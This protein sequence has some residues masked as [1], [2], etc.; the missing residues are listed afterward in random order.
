MSQRVESIINKE[1][2]RKT[3]VKVD[4]PEG[5]TVVQVVIERT[6]IEA[7]QKNVDICRATLRT[8]EEKGIGSVKWAGGRADYSDVRPGRV[9]LWTTGRWQIA[10]AKKVTVEFDPVVQHH[11]HA[12]L[13][14]F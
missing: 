7:R 4:V 3:K 6:P 9:G 8:D 5:M 13:D 12:H 11:V 2:Y 1:I 10:D 14:F